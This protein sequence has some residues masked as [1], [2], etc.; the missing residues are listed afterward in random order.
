MLTSCGQNRICFPSVRTNDAE[1]MLLFIQYSFGKVSLTAL[2]MMT[3]RIEMEQ[4]MKR[5]EGMTSH[6]ICRFGSSKEPQNY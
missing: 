6:K 4:G 1:F 3:W 5:R 2:K